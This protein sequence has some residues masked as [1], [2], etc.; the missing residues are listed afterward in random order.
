M[1]I[2][3]SNVKG[4][5]AGRGGGQGG[6]EELHFGMYNKEVFSRRSN[7]ITIDGLNYQSVIDYLRD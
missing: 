4:V 5:R 7:W 1:H 6:E 2:L 3:D